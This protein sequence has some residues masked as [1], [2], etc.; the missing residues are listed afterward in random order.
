MV[1]QGR[2]LFIVV[3]QFQSPR[4]LLSHQQL[5]N[6]KNSNFGCAETA[7]IDPFPDKLLGLV[8]D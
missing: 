6:K 4:C 5:E 2:R 3:A 7:N 1:R 8:D